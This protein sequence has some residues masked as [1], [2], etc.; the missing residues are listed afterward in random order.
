V[1]IGFAALPGLGT[2]EVRGAVADAMSDAIPSPGRIEE[3]ASPFVFVCA[4]AGVIGRLAA[5]DA[6]EPVAP[7]YE[8]FLLFFFAIASAALYARDE[9]ERMGWASRT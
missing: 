5:C 8:S 1:S 4:A 2:N 3:D 9:R 6:V 7:V